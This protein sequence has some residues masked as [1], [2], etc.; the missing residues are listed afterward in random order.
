MVAL[1]GLPELQEGVE[2]SGGLLQRGGPDDPPHLL[3]QH[4]VERLRRR[5]G[6]PEPRAQ[7]EAR[8]GL[9]ARVA[10]QPAG[11]AQPQAGGEEGAVH[12]FREDVAGEEHVQRAAARQRDA[13]RAACSAAASICAYAQLMCNE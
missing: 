2:L 13:A 6:V 1:Q 4:A 12:L 7:Q 5:L 8:H 3:P 10:A 11:R 9:A